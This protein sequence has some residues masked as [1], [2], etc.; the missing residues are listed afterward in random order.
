MI[1]FDTGDSAW[2]VGMVISVSAKLLHDIT[3]QTIRE[4]REATSKRKESETGDNHG[5]GAATG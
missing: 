3:F 1:S 4:Q 2:L 5:F